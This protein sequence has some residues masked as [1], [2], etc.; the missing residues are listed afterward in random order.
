MSE[1]DIEISLEMIAS[2]ELEKSIAADLESEDNGK[3]I[4]LLRENQEQSGE[5]V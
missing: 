2:E 4:E 3:I 1:E 5:V